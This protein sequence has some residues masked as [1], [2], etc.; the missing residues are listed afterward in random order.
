MLCNAAGVPRRAR[1]GVVVSG[2]PEGAGGDVEQDIIN[3]MAALAVG[4]AIGEF[5]KA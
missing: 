4:Y 3:G 1:G 5:S 2:H